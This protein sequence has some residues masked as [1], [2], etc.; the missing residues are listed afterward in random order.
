VVWVT[1]P[2]RAWFMAM[3]ELFEMRI[4][5]PVIR[6]MQAFPVSRDSAD[7]SALRFA[8]ARLKEGEAV[9]IFPEGRG[10]PEGVM[11]PFQPGAAFIALRANA[12]V[13]PVGIIGTHGMLPYGTAWPKRAPHPVQVRYGQPI[14]YDDL[15]DKPRHEA[16]DELTR[17]M[18]AAV[19][20]LAEQ[21]MPASETP[22]AAS[23]GATV[24][25]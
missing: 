17:R 15:R 12:T 18:E 22:E 2:R 9:V 10:N 7:R 13:L 24:Q 19:A 8:E 1:L 21:P 16:L 11:A 4:L 23:V 6:Y 25:K 3:R 20:Q 5:G 14:P